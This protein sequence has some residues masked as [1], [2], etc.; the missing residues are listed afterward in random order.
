MSAIYVLWLREMKRF[1]R[2]K[3]RVLSSLVM[4]LLFLAFLGTGFKGASI[5]GAGQ[6]Y[7]D[8]LSPGILGML[9]LFSSTFAGVTVIMDKEFGFLKE[10]MVAPVS[11]T[12]I[13]LGR[14]AGGTTTTIIQTFIVLVLSSFLGF[15]FNLLGIPMTILAI[16]LSSAVFISIGLI[17]ASLMEQV[18]GFNIIVNFFI[19]PMFFISGAITPITSFPEPLRFI[20]YL[21]PLTYGIDLMRAALTGN[22]L[23]PV[24]ISLPII[25]VFAVVFVLMSAYIF[26]KTEVK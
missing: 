22:S 26:D 17:F 16:F 19:F 18:E 23:L 14:I 6:N 25:S 10:V 2:S 12:S 9:V 1:W 13:A 4:P 7:V 5:P 20:S 3:S 11:R 21:S 8:F 15:Q 24:F